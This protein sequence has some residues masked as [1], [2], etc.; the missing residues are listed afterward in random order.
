M[1][2]KHDD[3]W[4]MT[5]KEQG[6]NLLR[7]LIPGMQRKPRLCKDASVIVTWP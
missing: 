3:E 6:E 7:I 1:T 2:F 5:A 4:K